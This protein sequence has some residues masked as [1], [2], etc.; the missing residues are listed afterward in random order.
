MFVKGIAGMGSPV[1]LSDEPGVG[2]T[3]QPQGTASRIIVGYALV[4]KDLN[5]EKRLVEVFVK[6]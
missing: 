4:E 3:T 6:C 5:E 1:Y 2:T